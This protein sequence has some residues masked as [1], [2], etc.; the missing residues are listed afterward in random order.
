MNKRL[1][2]LLASM[3][4][5]CVTAIGCGKQ[6]PK[7]PVNIDNDLWEDSIVVIRIIYNTYEK[8]NNFLVED[9]DVIEKYFDTYKGRM[10]DSIEENELINTVDNLYRDYKTYLYSKRVGLK[11]KAEDRQKVKNQFKE[12]QNRYENIL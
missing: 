7:T 1:I 4:C 11:D 8:D 10:Y 12:L 3:I 6:M 2:I 9:E 5:I